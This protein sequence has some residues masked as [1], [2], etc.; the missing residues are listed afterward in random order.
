MGEGDQN[1]PPIPCHRT[2]LPFTVNKKKRKSQTVTSTLAQS[3]GP[4]AL[5]SL[6][7]KRKKPKSKKT[8]IEAHVTLPSVPIED[9]EQSYS[10]SSGNVPDPQDPREKTTPW[11]NVQPVDKGFTST[12]SKDGTGTITHLLEGPHRDKDSEGFKPPVDMEPLATLGVDPSRTDAKYQADQTQSARLS[13][14][15][16]VFEAGEEIDEDIPPTNEEAQ[17]LVKYLQQVF[18]ELYNQLTSDYSEKHKEAAVSYVDVNAFIE[19]TDRAKLLKALNRVSE[20]LETYYVLKNDMK[21]MAETTTTTSGNLT[22]LAELLTNANLPEVLTKL[23][24]SRMSFSTPFVSASDPTDP[25][26]E[27]HA[28]VR[29]E[30]LKQAMT[31]SELIKVVHEEA[32][33]AR[34]DPK[35]IKSV[36]GGEQFK[37]TR[38]AEHKVL[39]REHSRKVKITME[40]RKNILEQYMWTTSN[41]LR[42]EPITDAKIHPNSKPA[43]LNVYRANDR[44]NFQVH[45]PFKFAYFR[46]IKLDE[47]GPIIQKKK[48]DFSSSCPEQAQSQSSRRKG[49]HM[50][51]K[52]KIRDVFGDEAFQRMSDIN[53]VRFDALLTYLV[54]ASNIITPKNTRFCLKLRNLIEDHPDQEKLQSKKVK[55]ESNRVDRRWGWDGKS[56]NYETEGGARMAENLRIPWGSPV[57]VPNGDGDVKR[58]FDGDEEGEGGRGGM[59]SEKWN[60]R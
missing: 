38:D 24:G 51:L 8:P 60:W 31:K 21:K 54:M 30:N 47:L 35:I 13:N 22:S 9:S 58:F 59:E 4:E 52:L 27:V 32:E 11:G 39:K 25:Q 26:P 48:K 19:G 29:R 46:V 34:I 50:E 49:K 10:V 43:A 17:Q 37:K 44:R 2:P 36:K 20:T 45:N 42:P 28:S 57:L 12:A 15:D 3:Q 6:P 53:K 18:Q 56:S 40:L 23:D 7:Q 5:G 33:K 14:E 55:L 41:R 1:H 16:D